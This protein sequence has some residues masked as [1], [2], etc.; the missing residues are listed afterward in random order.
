M[1]HKAATLE[2]FLDKMHH[3]IDS[4]KCLWPVCAGLRGVKPPPSPAQAI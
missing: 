1:A 4:E 3:F 2:Q